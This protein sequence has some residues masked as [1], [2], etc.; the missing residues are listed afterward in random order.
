MMRKRFHLAG[1]AQ[2]VEFYSHYADK[3]EVAI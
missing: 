3:F 1:L 2:T